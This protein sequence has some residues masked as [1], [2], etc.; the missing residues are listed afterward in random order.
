MQRFWKY[1]YFCI[2][3]AQL[4]CT[5]YHIPYPDLIVPAFVTIDS[6]W[7]EFG[8][9]L[10]DPVHSL[11]RCP[12]WHDCLLLQQPALFTKQQKQCRTRLSCTIISVNICYCQ[13][14]TQMDKRFAMWKLNITVKEGR[15]FLC[16]GSSLYDDQPFLEI[17]YIC[18]KSQC[19]TTIKAYRLHLI[20]V[21]IVDT[22]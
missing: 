10:Y 3:C 14:R 11:V 22:K 19:V 7:E 15:I 9:R 16:S 21:D 13:R 5:I 8:I 20:L 2:I 12:S 6:R 18:T 17:F 1:S 4:L